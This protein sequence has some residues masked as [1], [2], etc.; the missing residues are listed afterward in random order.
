MGYSVMPSEIRQKMDTVRFHRH[1][2]SKVVKP[3][4]TESG[5]HGLPMGGVFN[6]DRVSV[7]GGEEFCCVDGGDSGCTTV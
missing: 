6:G 1:E 4:E 5:C 3:V 2:V 7:W